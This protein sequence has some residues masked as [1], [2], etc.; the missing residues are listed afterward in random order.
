M[1]TGEERA[2]LARLPAVV[3]VYRGCYANN[4]RGFSW[5]LDPAIAATFPT[6]NRYR[7]VGQPLLIRATVERDAILAL[8]LD[9][10]EQEVIAERPKIVA[11]RHIRPAQPPV[12]GKK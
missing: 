2:A 8:K 5:S 10:E 4:K 3:T 7:Q 1:M 12:K 11:I 6:L 9:R